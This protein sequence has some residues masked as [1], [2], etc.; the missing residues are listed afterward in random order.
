MSPLLEV[1]GRL[2]EELQA[3]AQR[4]EEALLLEAHGLLDHA[5]AAN[6]FGIGLAHF[7]DQRRHDAVDHRLAGAEQGRVAHGAAHDAAQH[8]AAALVGRQDAV[9]DEEAHRAQVVGDDAEARRCRAR[10]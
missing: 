6:Q 10:H 8:I 9:G 4:L 1:G 3:A 5:F 2:V 7:R